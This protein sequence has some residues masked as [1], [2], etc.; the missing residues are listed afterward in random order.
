MSETAQ[1]DQ[2]KKT[3]LMIARQGGIV[4][5]G[6]VISSVVRF[7]TQIILGRALGAEK[8]GLYALGFSLFSIAGQIA[9]LGLSEGIIK[10]GTV[11]KTE[12]DQSRLKG[13]LQLA[14][15]AVAVAAAIFAMV[16]FISAPYIARDFFSKSELTPVLKFFALSIPLFALGMISAAT[17]RA[18]QN[19]TDYALIQYLLHPVAFIVF[20][21]A[22]F[23]VGPTL[24]NVLGAFVLAWV[25]VLIFSAL[26]ILK[27]SPVWRSRIQPVY[28]KKEW[29]R[30][31]VPVFLAKWLP[32]IINNFDKIILGKLVLAGDLG[33]YNAGS[34]VAAQILIFMQA[35]NLILAPIIAAHFHS[36]KIEELNALFKT[37]TYWTVTLTLPVVLWMMLNAGLIMSIFGT[38]FTIGRNI[39]ILCCLAQFISVCTGP[40]EYILIMGR[41]DLHLIN[42]LVLAFI[43]VALNIILINK[44]GVLGA[45]LTLGFSTVICNLVRLVEV[46]I[47]YRLFPYNNKFL[48]TILITIIVAVFSL[49]TNKFLPFGVFNAVISFVIIFGGF[50][51]LLNY[52]GFDE[53]DRVVISLIKRKVGGFF[54]R[55]ISS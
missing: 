32:L 45:I 4:I 8:Y 48:K 36:N 33:I 47:L 31:V 10:F 44:Y 30:F 29:F 13:L 28:E 43:T 49:L 51:V 12:N 55:D 38:E 23:L 26:S 15:I 37:V 3:S 9:Q 54:M 46:Y 52:W 50:Y 17:A 6:S 39:L 35:L 1:V 16:V 5:V 18:M 22:I 27:T 21:G 20:I 7:L 42:N 41:Q 40:L 2:A 19:I 53:E 24:G 11:Y 14:V 25:L 34:K